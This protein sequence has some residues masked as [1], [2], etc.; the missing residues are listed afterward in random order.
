MGRK[1]RILGKDTS[2]ISK[3]NLSPQ[4]FVKFLKYANLRT[5]KK[6]ILLTIFSFLIISCDKPI[7]GCFHPDIHNKLELRVL[8]SNGQNL[9]DPHNPKGID[10]NN[11]HTYHVLY[12]DLYK[13][14]TYSTFY[15]HPDDNSVYQ[16]DFYLDYDKSED[17]SLTLIQWNQT[18]FDTVKGVFYYDP[19]PD[20]W[21]VVL[22]KAWYN[23]KKMSLDTPNTIIKNF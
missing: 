17:T 8:D 21:R 13:D 20:V 16:I 3:T 23:G 10:L 11:V 1:L 7:C 18:D 19:D 15:A 9:L 5:M 12:H 14:T 6:L 4:F 22:Q 2:V